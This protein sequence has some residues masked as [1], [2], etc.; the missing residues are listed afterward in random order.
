[1]KYFKVFNT[2]QEYTKY[3]VSGITPNVSTLRDSSKTWI[4]AEC[5]EPQSNDYL[6]FVAR[7][8][9]TFS[10][11]NP[12]EYSLDSGETWTVLAANTSTPTIASGE[13]IMWKKTVATYGTPT[14]VGTFSA[15][16][17]FD[18]EGNAMSLIYG[19]NFAWDM[20]GT[21]AICLF[22]ILIML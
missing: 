8:N 9:A 20:I 4:N 19:D 12:I 18:A 17:D 21:T 15:T 13:K 3:I 5:P 7:E 14:G 16:R 22:V 10:F 11:T 1:M 6:A 2:E